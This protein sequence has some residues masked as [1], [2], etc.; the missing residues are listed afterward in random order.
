[1]SEK[2]EKA[3]Q[4]CVIPDREIGFPLSLEE[5]AE[6]ALGGGATMIQLRDKG[7][8]GRE[9]YETA[10]RLKEL[11]RKAGVLLI[12]NDRFDVALASGADGAHLGI[13]DL[14]LRSA[15]LLSPPG[16]IL[17]GTAHSVKEARSA[18]ADGADYVG[19]GAAYPSTAKKEARVLGPE[20]IREVVSAIT[21]PVIAIG[22]ISAENIGAVLAAGAK[23][24]AVIGSAVGSKDIAAVVR[25]MA[26]ILSASET[27][28]E[29]VPS[30][31]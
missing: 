13:S 16:F 14:P 7:M 22:G 1:M 8:S 3:L 27:G 5:Q 2:L 31:S 19:V 6:Q 10:C 17:G 26:E 9:L 4:L 18:E 30:L 11:C 23:G 28:G 15:R 20:G 29:I 24:A 21:I 12:V 25:G